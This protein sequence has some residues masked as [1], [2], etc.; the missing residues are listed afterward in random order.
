MLTRQKVLLY[1][2]RAAK[3]P[4]HRIELTK[5]AFLLRHDT[6]SQGGSAFYDFVPYHYGPFSF[7]LYQELGKLE[8]QGYVRQADENHWTAATEEADDSPLEIRRDI[9][10]IINR[11]SRKDID[12]LLDEVY[13][14][15]PQFT[16][17]SKRRRL[18]SRP[19]GEPA[20]YTSGY[21]GLSIDAFLN[22]LIQS[23]IRHL[24]DVRRNPIARRYG[25]HKSTLS[26]LCASLEIEY[27]HLP[28]LGIASD[29]R[30]SL[31]TQRDYDELFAEYRNTTLQ[32]EPEAISLIARTVSRKPSVL[33]CM[34]A[35]PSCC[36]RTHLAKA[37]SLESK[38]DIHHLV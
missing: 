20:V 14:R 13:E 3:R 34:E 15:H 4:V 16:V 30:R 25:F 2:I 28:E 33:V 35:Q 7:A 12:S 1:L 31:E 27:S 37:V 36:H 22:R 24:I 9:N 5:W 11:H 23:G 26:R 6:Q 29:K 18:K 21:E 19:E 32:S 38:L 8:Q 10:A 17:N